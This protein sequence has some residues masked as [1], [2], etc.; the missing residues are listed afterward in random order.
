MLIVTTIYYATGCV[1]AEVEFVESTMNIGQY[2]L[3]TNSKLSL[4]KDTAYVINIYLADSLLVSD[5]SIS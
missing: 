1:W 5:D 4:L 3:Q 2:D